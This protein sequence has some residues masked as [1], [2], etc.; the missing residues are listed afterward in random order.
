MSEEIKNAN[1]GRG[2][3]KPK[4]NNRRGQREQREFE[5]KIL[6]LARV[7]RVTKGGKRMRFRTCLIIGDRKG[8]V[9]M[10]VAKGADVAASVEKA[11]RQ[12][13]KNIVTVPFVNG[14]IPHEVNIKYGAAQILIKPAPEG[15]GLKSGGPIRLV[16]E[17]AGVPNAVSKVLGGSSKINNAKATF[18]ALR[19]LKQVDSKETK[20]NKAKVEKVNADKKQES[21]KLAAE[22]ESNKKSE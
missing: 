20:V 21:E 19:S 2:P 9:G 22:K 7:T 5:Q 6:D 4:R 16:L 11:F 12:A 17:L 3:R 18:K 14:T 13:K 10:G 1:K 15:T 8:R